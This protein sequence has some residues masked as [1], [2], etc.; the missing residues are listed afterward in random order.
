MEISITRQSE[1]INWRTDGVF[2]GIEAMHIMTLTLLDMYEYY[3]EKPSRP[4]LPEQDMRVCVEMKDD[5]LHVSYRPT[6]DAHTALAICQAAVCGIYRKS[7]QEDFDAMEGV[8]GALI[9]D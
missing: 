9:I 2:N 5:K 6:A 8:L 4:E 7:L 3:F 1:D